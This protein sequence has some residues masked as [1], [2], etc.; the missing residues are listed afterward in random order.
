MSLE[1]VLRWTL[2]AIAIAGLAAGI[3]A[4]VAGRPA[5][6]CA[7]VTTTTARESFLEAQSKA[8]IERA[9]L[10]FAGRAPAQPGFA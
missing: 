7:N 9:P 8:A 5:S 1:R 2:V 4:R 3:L 10:R 6:L